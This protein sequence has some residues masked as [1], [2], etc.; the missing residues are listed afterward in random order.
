MED[1]SQSFKR[2]APNFH[3]SLFGE[4]DELEVIGLIGISKSQ[5]ERGEGFQFGLFVLVPAVE[6]ALSDPLDVPG[7]P[8]D[9][10]EPDP[11]CDFIF[12][13]CD[14]TV[15]PELGEC[16]FE[17]H[18]LVHFGGIA[19][20]HQRK[21]VD[22]SVHDV[23][24]LEDVPYVSGA[25]VLHGQDRLLEGEPRDVSVDYGD[26][27][28]EAFVGVVDEGLEVEV[29]AEDGLLLL[30]LLLWRGSGDGLLELIYLEFEV[31]FLGAECFHA[32]ELELHFFGDGLLVGHFL[33]V[34]VDVDALYVARF[35]HADQLPIV[36]PPEIVHEDGDGLFVQFELVDCLSLVFPIF[37]LDESIS[38]GDDRHVVG[39]CAVGHHLQH[40]VRG[41]GPPF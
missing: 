21:T 32:L 11:A 25:V 36:V 4:E 31:Q 2:V 1:F 13:F 7:V 33:H 37:Q 22:L 20:V 12:G 18:G 10:A 30:S 24:C 14:E 23:L 19:R 28:D 5:F 17:G 6:E 9:I 16:D 41:L 29:F 26:L 8:L 35:E 39:F 40:G 34:L 27:E 38:A 3:L 15:L